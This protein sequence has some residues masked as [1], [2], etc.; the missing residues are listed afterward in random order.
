MGVQGRKTRLVGDS[1]G[2]SV[3]DSIGDSAGDCIVDN[4]RLVDDAVVGCGAR[5]VG[6]RIVTGTSLVGLFHQVNIRWN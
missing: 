3:D 6:D 1:V 4:R 5:L 2:D